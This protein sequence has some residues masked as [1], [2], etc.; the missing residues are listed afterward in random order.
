[1]CSAFHRYRPHQGTD[2][3]RDPNA[4]VHHDIMVLFVTD[5]AF[6]LEKGRRLDNVPEKCQKNS[7]LRQAV[8]GGERH[9]VFRASAGIALGKA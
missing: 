6:E 4:R 3:S 9:H 5:R 7:L 1:M 2:R 8:Q